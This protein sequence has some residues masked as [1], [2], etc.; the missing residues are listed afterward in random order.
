MKKAENKTSC[1][2]SLYWIKEFVDF[3]KANTAN[4]NPSLFINRIFLNKLG[5]TLRHRVAALA[6]RMFPF[7]ETL[8]AIAVRPPILNVEFANICNANC[9]FCPYQFQQRKKTLMSDT[10]FYKT[11]DN[12]VSIGGGPVGLTPMVGDALVH[13]KFIKW[14]KYLRS[15]PSI[16]KV[17]LTTNGLFLDK[18]GIDEVLN[19]GV[20][21]IILSTAGFKRSMYQRIYRTNSYDRMRHNCEMLL[22]KNEKKGHLVDIRIA[23]RP[24]RPL[25]EVMRD[26][27]FQSILAYNPP[28]TFHWSLGNS[29]GKIVNESLPE[30]I[31][32]QSRYDFKEPCEY[33]MRG[34][35][36]LS[37]G[38]VSACCCSPAAMDAE[39]DLGIGNI[40]EMSLLKMWRS[41]KMRELLNSF[42]L[43]RLNNSCIGCG[44]YEGLD[45]FR[46]PTGR[47]MAEMNLARYKSAP[48]HNLKN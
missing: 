21:S 20:T 45:L 10:V 5:R 14:V 11:V 1:S 33:I 40:L 16:E 36:V 27:D 44:Q 22:K 35:L 18:H 9:V 7:K 26:P 3:V 24:D 38:I 47:K 37:N 39:E 4:A 8:Y 25:V 15:F 6:G 46:T 34:P 30:I 48:I 29:K 28:L 2:Q 13:P 41:L 19:S 31:S 12:W 17:F 23:L 32:I 42:Y 43:K